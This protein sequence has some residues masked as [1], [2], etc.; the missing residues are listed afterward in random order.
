[1]QG[2]S[3]EKAS[4]GA[5]IVSRD[6]FGQPGRA[7]EDGHLIVTAGSFH[8]CPIRGLGLAPAGGSMDRSPS[9]RQTARRRGTL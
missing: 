5:L 2:Q 3:I 6:A 8:C 4:V 9:A 7:D 1:M